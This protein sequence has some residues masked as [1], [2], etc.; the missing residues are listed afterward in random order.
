M[1]RRN[2]KGF[3]LVELLVVVAI[4]GLLAGII[5]IS[6]NNA[7][8]RARDARRLSDI[9]AIISALELYYNDNES[10]PA[11]TTDSCCNGWDQGPCDGDN[12]FIAGL[13]S[14]GYISEVPVDPSGG[15]GISCYGYNYYV[16]SAGSSG[17]DSSRG[18]FYVL[19]VRD[20]ETSG[21]PHLQSLG[22]SCPGRNWQ[23]EFDWVTGR[24]EQ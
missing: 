16:Y 17:C 3:T 15:S 18:A 2:D 22:W 8:I 13:I 4:I 1:E 14:G 6:L 19:G 21:R 23:N 24:F 20:M 12:T 7:R 10:Y 5:I 9:R 11:R